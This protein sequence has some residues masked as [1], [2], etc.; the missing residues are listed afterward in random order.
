MSKAGQDGQHRPILSPFRLL[1]LL[2]LDAVGVLFVTRL[3]ADAV[4]PLAI[5]ILL[6]VV[7]VNIVFLRPELSPI[8][9]LTPGL[10]LAALFAL[11]PVIFTVYTSFTNYGTGNILTREQ[12]VGQLEGRRYTPDD[13][14][15]FQWHL[16]ESPGGD[17]ML[18]LVDDD[19]ERLLATSDSLKP[20]PDDIDAEYPADDAPDEINGSQLVTG[21]ALLTRL[22]E[23]EGMAFGDPERPVEIRSSS[24]AR[25]VRQRYHFD[26]DSGEIE[27]L[28]DEVV[29]TAD[30]SVGYFVDEE[31]NRLLPGFRVQTGLSNYVRLIQSPALRG[32]LVTI[33]IWTFI[34]AG[35][36]VA[37][38][39]FLGLLLAYAAEGIPV[40]LRKP[41][42]SL[43][44]LPQAV[45]GVIG[46]LVW[47]GLLNRH[48]GAVT[49][50][51][52]ELFG[53]SPAWFSDPIAA[54][55]AVLLL[56][57]WLGFPY[58]MLVC[59]G[60]LQ[61][62]PGELYEA[63]RV[64]GAG[65]LSVFRR[66]TLP[67][68]LIAAGPVLISSFAMNFNNF[69]VI[70]LFNEGGPPIPGTPVPA[71]YTDI[72]IS[73]TYRLAFASGRG[74]DYGFA[75]AITVAIFAVLF[76]ITLVNYRYTRVWEEVSENG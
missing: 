27:D 38:T 16:Y 32:P 28:R 24:H 22:S 42:R 1:A 39:F 67:M 53:A 71:G 15:S 74:A 54:R 30:E 10:A 9:W 17:K 62:I 61:S 34:F 70:Y 25:E 23:L 14:R 55:L 3:L 64:D 36:S 29:Y 63:A 11:Y 49:A 48:V 59:S 47:R 5:A 50:I 19:G 33:F 8:R 40:R 7:A 35:V 65:I 58:M 4:Y 57:L 56:N 37:S 18:L 44:I 6:I 69:N 75:S 72:L 2:V 52:N 26:A 66:I 45:P 13:A 46:I 21:E 73:Y 68:V 51:L 31:G 12:V 20:V 76:V 60:A 43:L 41:L